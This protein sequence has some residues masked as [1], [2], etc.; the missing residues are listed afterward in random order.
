MVRRAL[1]G[2]W[3]AAAQRAGGDPPAGRLP[4]GGGP[5]VR[6]RRQRARCVAVAAAAAHAV[7]CAGRDPGRPR[8]GGP[9][10]GRAAVA[11]AAVADAAAAAALLPPLLRWNRLE[12]R[13]DAAVVVASQLAL[14][15]APCLPQLVERTVGE[16]RRIAVTAPLLM[17][18]ELTL[19]DILWRLAVVLCAGSS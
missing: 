10:V 15:A 4:R 1:A 19:K 8:P 18:S 11:S 17:F 3:C 7:L 6:R 16:G 9:G 12:L 2:S 5:A 14:L 13:L